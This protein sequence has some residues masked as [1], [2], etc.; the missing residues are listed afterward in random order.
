M[1]TN[2]DDTMFFSLG[3]SHLPKETDGSFPNEQGALRR[4]QIDKRDFIEKQ[5]K[6]E[7]NISIS[8]ILIFL[9]LENRILVEFNNNKCVIYCYITITF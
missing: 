7:H 5:G 3:E 9:T 1:D 4:E 6:R 8:L 2:D